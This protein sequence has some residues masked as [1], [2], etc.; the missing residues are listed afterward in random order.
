MPWDRKLF[1]SR[2]CLLLLG[3][4]Y[5]NSQQFNIYEMSNVSSEWSVKYNFNLDDNIILWPRTISC[6]VWCIVLGER[7][8]DS[9]IVMELDKKIVEYKIMSKNFLGLYDM[10]PGHAL[11][12][13]QFFVSFAGV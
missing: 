4:D 1:E 13:F 3:V 9:S 10:G 8:E 7:E 2:G 5:N 6:N 12:G 11:G